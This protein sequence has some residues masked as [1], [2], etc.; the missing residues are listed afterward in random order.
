MIFIE[1]SPR[2]LIMKGLN[3]RAKESLQQVYKP[4]YFDSAFRQT[5]DEIELLGLRSE[6]KVL[7][8]LEL[9][10]TTYRKSLL[11]SIFITGLNQFAG[12]TIALVYGPFIL[13]AAGSGFSFLTDDQNAVFLQ[14]PLFIVN[15]VGILLCLCFIDEYGR[16][17]IALRSLPLSTVGWLMTA[18]GFYL[19][20]YETI[21][22]AGAYIAFMGIVF[23]LTTYS[24]GMSGIPFVLNTEIFPIHLIGT[25]IGIA[26]M[27]NLIFN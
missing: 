26:T 4:A 21:P 14:I 8:R 16:R 15:L 20:F 19:T 12:I 18:L 9:L 24:I 27:F 5:V 23:F 17:H 25:G 3:E 2:W 13:I 10:F 7:K 1:E 11:I 22:Y 6:T